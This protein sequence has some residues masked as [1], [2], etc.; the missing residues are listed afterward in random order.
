MTKKLLIVA[1]TVI[2]ALLAGC[3]GADY[4]EGR[5]GGRSGSGHSH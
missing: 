1:V 5:A 4:S 2:A 3:V